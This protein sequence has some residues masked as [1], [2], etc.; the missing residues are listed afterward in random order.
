MRI[1]VFY[2]AVSAEPLPFFT[3]SSPHLFWDS[4]WQ[5]ARVKRR[6]RTHA[7]S[8][9]ASEALP[10]EVGARPSRSEPKLNTHALYPSRS[11]LRGITFKSETAAAHPRRK[12]RGIRGAAA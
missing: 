3:A 12:R 2:L 11:E 1:A 9:G 5:I 8:G 4:N 10:H 6:Q 7:A